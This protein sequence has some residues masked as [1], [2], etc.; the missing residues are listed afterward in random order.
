MYVGNP[1]SLGLYCLTPVVSSTFSHWLAER[2]AVITVAELLE[3]V[4]FRIP[5][6]AVRM[7]SQSCRPGE[8]AEVQSCAFSIKWLQ[9]H[10]NEKR[11][12]TSGAQSPRPAKPV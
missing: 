11:F 3:Y 1:I 7:L 12:F 8:L 5:P 2:L 4:Q 6:L 10:E 9:F